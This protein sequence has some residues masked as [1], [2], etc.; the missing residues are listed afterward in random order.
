MIEV[1]VK[2]KRTGL[3]DFTCSVCAVCEWVADELSATVSTV[4]GEVVRD[5]VRKR[6]VGVGF[7]FWR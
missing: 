1:K 6:S 2:C 5:V 3:L 4:I 7:C